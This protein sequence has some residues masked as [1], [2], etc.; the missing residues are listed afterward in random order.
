MIWIKNLVKRGWGKRDKN[1]CEKGPFP[2]RN[3]E[4][5]KRERH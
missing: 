1:K 4:V 3:K 2:N 5:L